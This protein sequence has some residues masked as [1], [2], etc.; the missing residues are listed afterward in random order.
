MRETEQ[1]GGG[2]GG[3]VDMARENA[4]GFKGINIVYL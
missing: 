1:E 2:G 4:K 3:G